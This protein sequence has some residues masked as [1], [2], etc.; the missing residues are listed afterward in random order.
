[1]VLRRRKDRCSTL[2]VLLLLLEDECLGHAL[3]HGLRGIS[4]YIRCLLNTAECLFMRLSLRGQDG[5]RIW[6]GF[7]Q[8]PSDSR[9]SRIWLSVGSPHR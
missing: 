5:Q 3:S 7:D 1:M 4:F 8:S 9:K 2:L 6:R